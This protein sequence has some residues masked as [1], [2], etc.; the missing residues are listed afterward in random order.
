MFVYINALSFVRPLVSDPARILYLSTFVFFWVAKGC[1]CLRTPRWWQPNSHHTDR[2]HTDDL[3]WCRLEAR[4][5]L[6]RPKVVSDLCT[7]CSERVFLLLRH[8][9]RYRPS[10][11]GHARGMRICFVP[12]P[13][14]WPPTKISLWVS[15][16]NIIWH[17]HRRWLRRLMKPGRQRSRGYKLWIFI[18]PDGMKGWS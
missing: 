6:L 13:W 3:R 17:K 7:S 16:Q 5:L 15:S 4:P 12:P 8:R 10:Y 9:S 1:M 11:H 2:R 18:T 14:P